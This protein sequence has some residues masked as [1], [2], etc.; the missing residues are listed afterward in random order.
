MS[1][2]AR[3]GPPACEKGGEAL[4]REPTKQGRTDR[5][6][7]GTLEEIST[8]AL[9]GF[10]EIGRPGRSTGKR[11][12]VYPGGIHGREET[13]AGERLPGESGPPSGLGIGNGGMAPPARRGMGKGDWV[14][15]IFIV[16]QLNLFMQWKHSLGNFWTSSLSTIGD[17]T[18]LCKINSHL[19]LGKRWCCYK[20]P[21]FGSCRITQRSRSILSRTQIS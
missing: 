18:F 13:V 7:P 12:K 11:S 3:K 19:F 4:V 10:E 15:L 1:G 20:F 5:V 8:E 14:I 2:W 6:G 9:S 21:G 16:C 17:Q